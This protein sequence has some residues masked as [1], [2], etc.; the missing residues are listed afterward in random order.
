MKDELYEKISKLLKETWPSQ[1]SQQESMSLSSAVNI[2]W[3]NSKP[4]EFVW[5]LYGGIAWRRAVHGKRL[6]DKTKMILLQRLVQIKC[7]KEER[8]KKY[9]ET[10]FKSLEEAININGD[11]SHLG[12][13][14]RVVG[15]I[16]HQKQ[17]YD[18]EIQVEEKVEDKESDKRTRWS[19]RGEWEE[20]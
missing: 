8:D 20:Y 3:D 19:I 16:Y 14:D 12:E 15:D 2:V 11:R 4:D 13:L 18:D 10:V 6:E 5:A 7:Q 1:S 9:E 17:F